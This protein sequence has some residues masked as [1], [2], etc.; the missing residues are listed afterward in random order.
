MR[1]VLHVALPEEGWLNL[2]ERVEAC[3]FSMALLTSVEKVAQH[4]HQTVAVK[5]KGGGDRDDDADGEREKSLSCDHGGK[6]TEAR[7]NES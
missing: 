3:D 6:R 7:L 1:Y 5:V 2:Y 4:T